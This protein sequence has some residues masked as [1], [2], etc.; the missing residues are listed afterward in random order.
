VSFKGRFQTFWNQPHYCGLN[1]RY[2][3]ASLVN[4]RVIQVGGIMSELLMDMWGFMKERKNSGSFQS[5]MW[6]V[7]L[8][9]LMVLTSGS[10]VAPFIYSIF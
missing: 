8:G 2:G 6:L 3:V 10:V 1:R 9:G 4:D 5:I 7:L